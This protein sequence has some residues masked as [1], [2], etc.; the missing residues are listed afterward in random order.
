MGEEGEEGEERGRRDRDG[1][2]GGGGGGESGELGCSKREGREEM[3]QKLVAF[4]DD[5]LCSPPSLLPPQQLEHKLETE[6]FVEE[7]TG[8]NIGPT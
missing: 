7:I 1:G 3:G 4:K 5:S 8:E 2:R 6:M